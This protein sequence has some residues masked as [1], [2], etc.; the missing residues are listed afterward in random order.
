MAGQNCDGE[1]FFTAGT[2][3]HKTGIGQ[4]GHARIGNEGKIFSLAQRV[5]HAFLF[6]LLIVIMHA[7]EALRL[8]APAGAGQ[9]RTTGIFSQYGVGFFKAASRPRAEIVCIAQRGAYNAER[10]GLLTVR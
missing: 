1:S 6:L 5:Q 8:Y 7:D 2:N 9:S 4:Y 3:Q 10:T